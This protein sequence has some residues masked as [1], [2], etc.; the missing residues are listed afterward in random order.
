[1]VEPA[2]TVVLAHGDTLVLS[3]QAAALAIAENKLLKGLTS[4]AVQRAQ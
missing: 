1:V 4:P 2:D 3:G